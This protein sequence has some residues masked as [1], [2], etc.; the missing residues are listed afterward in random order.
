MFLRDPKTAA[1]FRL[2]HLDSTAYNKNLTFI[3]DSSCKVRYPSIFER[4]LKR[5][6][7]CNSKESLILPCLVNAKIAV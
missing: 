6:Y 7:I 3:A 5:K 4:Y 1:A 2:C